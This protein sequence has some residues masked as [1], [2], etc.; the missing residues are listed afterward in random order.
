MHKFPITQYK[1][2]GE[3]PLDLFDTFNYSVYLIDF[4][5]NYLFV[6]NFVKSNLGARGADLIGKNIWKEFKELA[7][8]PTFQQLKA[9]MERRVTTNLITVS[10]LTSQRI[11]ITGYALEDC[12]YF[13]S[14]I[15]PD[16]ND[17]L[18]ELRQVMNRKDDN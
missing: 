1:R 16:R 11:S 13:T 10:P 17:L 7:S 12:Y 2:F 4:D 14:S 5:W 18:H 3:L 8:N 15:L 6:N 9:N